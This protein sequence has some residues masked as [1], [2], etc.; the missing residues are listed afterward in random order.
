LPDFIAD[1]V[2]ALFGSDKPGQSGAGDVKKQD[3][4]DGPDGGVSIEVR[5]KKLGLGEQD[6]G[7]T[8]TR[9]QSVTIANEDSTPVNVSKIFASGDFDLQK[10]WQDD[11]GIVKPGANCAI[12]VTFTPTAEGV[13]S[14]TLAITYNAPDSPQEV[15]LSGTGTSAPSCPAGQQYDF[16]E[17]QCVPLDNTTP[18]KCPAGQQESTTGECVSIEVD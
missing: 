12:K 17:G 9:P 16:A 18:I 3:G 1:P 7:T 2:R 6:M 14:G 4:G 10:D 15:L 11:C 5:P 8:S 13:R